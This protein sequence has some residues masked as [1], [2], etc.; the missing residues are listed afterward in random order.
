MGNVECRAL[1]FS[2]VRAPT[3]RAAIAGGN[4][5]GSHD[6]ETGCKP[7]RGALDVVALRRRSARP[8]GA[9]GNLIGAMSQGRC[10]WLSQRRTFGAQ[11]ALLDTSTGLTPLGF[12]ASATPRARNRR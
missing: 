3:G 1:T 6:R 8:V 12:H 5:P 9:D 10:P 4:A 11:S 2:R 7:Q